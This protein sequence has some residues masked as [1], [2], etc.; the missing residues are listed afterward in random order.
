MR[1]NRFVEIPDAELEMRFSRSSG[2][3]GQNVNKRDTKVE[4]VFDVASSPS[5]D[6]DR[7]AKLM[8][9]LRSRLDADGRLHIVA[10]DGRTQTENRERALER[11]RATLARALAPPP[12]KRVATKPSKGAKER[13]L[14]EKKTRAKNKRMR[15]R[16]AIDE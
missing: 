7:R 4:V 5:L 13:R 8:R 14:T 11:M 16:P 6:E 10:Q 12:K 9:A 2:P 3:G 1:V 15:A